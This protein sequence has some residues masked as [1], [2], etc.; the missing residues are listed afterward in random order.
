[1]V[2][3]KLEF[4]FGCNFNPPY[5][6]RNNN[7]TFLYPHSRKNGILK[8]AM[9]SIN[10]WPQLLPYQFTKA[11]QVRLSYINNCVYMQSSIYSKNYICLLLW[12]TLEHVSWHVPTIIG[13]IGQL[14]LSASTVIAC[15]SKTIKKIRFICGLKW[16][17]LVYANFSDR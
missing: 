3:Y 1:M 15:V 9:I 17:P 13:Q 4:L 6:L 5:I 12:P 11:N 14:L 10:Y 7:N 8:F 2:K 16:R